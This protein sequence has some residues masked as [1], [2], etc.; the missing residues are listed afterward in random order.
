MQET[1][2]SYLGWD[3][4]WRRKWLTTTIFL[5]GEPHG[6]RAWQDTARGVI[7]SQTQLNDYT[8]TTSSMVSV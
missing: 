6:Q 5:P 2:V 3:D 4:P 1:Q 7:K 8:T